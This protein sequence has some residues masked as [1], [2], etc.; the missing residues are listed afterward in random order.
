MTR[1]FKTHSLVGLAVVCFCLLL[2]ACQSG[3]NQKEL[4]ITTA[5]NGFAGFPS[6]RPYL[7][8]YVDT[9]K[10][11]FNQ[12]FTLEGYIGGKTIKLVLD[13][14]ESGQLQETHDISDVVQIA[15]SGEYTFQA[16]ISAYAIPESPIQFNLDRFVVHSLIGLQQ[17]GQPALIQ[18]STPIPMGLSGN[19]KFDSSAYSTKDMDNLIL[20]AYQRTVSGEGKPHLFFTNTKDVNSTV[21]NFVDQNVRSANGFVI[22]YVIK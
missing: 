17:N 1:F 4:T 18:K 14:Y 2:T 20:M 16:K 22:R 10:G 15:E 9:L 19:Y 12:D 11:V 13:R 5:D 8:I 7:P 3:A 6:V 21:K